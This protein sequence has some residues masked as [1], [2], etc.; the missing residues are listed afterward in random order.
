MLGE[1][2]DWKGMTKGGKMHIFP[3]IGKKYPYFSPNWLEIYKTALKKAEIFRLRRS[4]AHHIKFHLGKK[5][6]SRRGGG[7]KHEFQI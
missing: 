4:T 6:E 3:P 2:N 5:Y 7:Q 1:K